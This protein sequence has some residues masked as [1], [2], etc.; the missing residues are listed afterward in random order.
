MYKYKLDLFFFGV[1]LSDECYKSLKK[2]LDGKVN[3]NDYIT[4]KG[5]HISLNNEAYVNADINDTS[6]YKIDY[7]DFKY[8]LLRD[9]VYICDVYIS[10]P[11]DFALY[12]KTISNGNLVTRLVNLHGDRLRIQP[13]EGCFNWCKFCP[14]GKKEYVLFTIQE[15]EEAFHI[16]LGE[17]AFKHILISGGTPMNRQEDFNYLLNVYKFFGEKY[18][19]FYPIDV[20]LV[21]RGINPNMSTKE[22]YMA[23]LKLLKSFKITGIYANLELYNDEY[24]RRLIP[25][26]DIVGKKKYIEFI[27]CAVSIFGEGNVKSCVIV[28]LEPLEDTLRGVELIAS[29]G[30]MPVL[31]PYEP[32]GNEDKPSIELMERVLLESDKIVK[33]YN[34]E[35][36]PK[37]D[38]CKHN[39]IHF[40]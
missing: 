21:P 33:K 15:L 13:I 26:K 36:G 30:C 32:I 10:Q 16:A 18:G 24:R 5:L 2:G 9:N 25:G 14:L 12:N 23:F 7:Y 19:D 27:E 37:C 22:D 31:S 17:R 35:L 38:M 3:F 34:T 20:M 4:T 39:T 6:M 8:I 28:G 11:P 40:K 29:T 1:R